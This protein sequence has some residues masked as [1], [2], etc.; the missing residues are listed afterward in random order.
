M[1]HLGGTLEV[2]F[3]AKPAFQTVRATI[4]RWRDRSLAE[5]ASGGNRKPIGIRKAQSTLHSGR[6]SGVEEE[7][8]LVCAAEPNLIRIDKRI[9]RDG[10]PQSLLTVCDGA[11]EWQRDHDGHVEYKN[12]ATG[13]GGNTDF[14][15]HFDRSL[16]REFL[17]SLSLE[18]ISTLRVA[19]R[20]CVHVRAALRPG[21][22]VWPHWLPFGADDYE[23]C[24]DRERAVLLAIIG[25]HQGKEFE[26]SEVREVTFDE[27]LDPSLF[28]FSPADGEQVHPATPIVEHLTLAAAID[29]V[30]FTVFVPTQ[31]PDRDHTQVHA[32][33]HPPR[34]G[35]GRPFLT[36]MY[37]NHETRDHLSIEQSQWPR[38]EPDRLEWS[39]L[40]SAGHELFISDPGDGTRVVTL[41]LQGTNICITS[42]LERERL[43][44]LASCLQPAA[45]PRCGERGV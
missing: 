41:K 4:Q 39:R 40:E 45:K 2:L 29:R 44:E 14:Q 17:K 33:F 15:R 31:L 5:C 30:P 35:A 6:V 43:I 28:S 3:G 36:L 42:S 34:R 11:I 7:T 38:G 10:R 26:R 32:I 9:T 24:F 27:P 1:A 19:D 16:I 25:R 37:M 18:E 20:E 22:R 8:L 13:K 23:F 12:A 21:E